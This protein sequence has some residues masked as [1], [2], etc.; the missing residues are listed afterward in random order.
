[1]DDAVEV[2]GFGDVFG[3][4]VFPAVGEQ[5]GELLAELAHFVR[6][7]AKVVKAGRSMSV[8]NPGWGTELPMTRCKR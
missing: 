5:R 4:E 8:D 1:V 7:L 3:V 6:V 2:H